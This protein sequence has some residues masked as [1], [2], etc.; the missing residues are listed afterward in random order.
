MDQVIYYRVAMILAEMGLHGPVSLIEDFDPHYCIKNAY[1]GQAIL[2]I[3]EMKGQF[4]FGFLLQ[5]LDGYKIQVH[6]RFAN[7]WALWTDVFITSVFPPEE[8]YQKMVEESARGRD[9][10]QQLLRRIADITY[11]FVDA[12]G[13][14]QRYTMP[15]SEY[16]DY[17]ELKAAAM[18]H[19][20]TAAPEIA[21]FTEEAAA[22]GEDLPF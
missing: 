13:E 8:L 11:C 21:G 17:E 4:P 9:K 18:E 2:F 19:I 5:I 3:D 16:S 10:Q 14:Y 6:A 12:A 7:I 20:E 22:D 1:Q 15:M